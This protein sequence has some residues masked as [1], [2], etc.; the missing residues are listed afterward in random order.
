[1]VWEVGAFA[2]KGRARLGG[3]MCEVLCGKR[4]AKSA[5]MI[6]GKTVQK[7]PPG[8]GRALPGAR[9]GDRAQIKVADQRGAF[10][11]SV[12]ARFFHR[13]VRICCSQQSY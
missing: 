12:A 13:F 9:P 10:L 4:G 3:R 8:G 7:R 6:W 5:T 11:G 1:M 2:T